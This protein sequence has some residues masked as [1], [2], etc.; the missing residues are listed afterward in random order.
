MSYEKSTICPDPQAIDMQSP[1]MVKKTSDNQ[2]PWIDLCK[3]TS[4]ITN[5]NPI[6]IKYS[7]TPSPKDDKKSPRLKYPI[8]QNKSFS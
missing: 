3:K 7:T 1:T 8:P 5:P 2:L 4:G 6:T